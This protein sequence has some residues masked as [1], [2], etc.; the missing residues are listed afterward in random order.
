VHVCI[1]VVDKDCLLV[2]VTVNS[3]K[4]LVLSQGKRNVS[5]PNLAFFFKFFC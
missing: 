3:L 2:C 1:Q 5:K 4:R